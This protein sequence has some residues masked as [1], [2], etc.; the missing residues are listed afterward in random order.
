MI[1]IK[2]SELLNIS[3]FIMS[4]FS[5]DVWGGRDEVRV[6]TKMYGCVFTEV[7]KLAFLRSLGTNQK[8]VI[9]K[10]AKLI[11]SSYLD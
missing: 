11:K 9:K 4:H 6:C 10:L 1:K 5:M 3:F 2:D 7:M 8:S